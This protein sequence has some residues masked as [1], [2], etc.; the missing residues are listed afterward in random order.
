MAQQLQLEEDVNTLINKIERL[1]KELYQLVGEEIPPDFNQEQVYWLSQRL[2]TL[3]V[4]FMRQD[5]KQRKQE[6]QIV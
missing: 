6:K 4:E 5:K 3:I 2:D 1:R